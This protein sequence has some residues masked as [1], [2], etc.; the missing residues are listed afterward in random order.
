MRDKAQEG[1]DELGRQGAQA[2]AAGKRGGG[3]KEPN[4]RKGAG[5]ARR[6]NDGAGAFLPSAV[7]IERPRPQG[8]RSQRVDAEAVQGNDTPRA[9]GSQRDERSAVPES[10]PPGPGD[11]I[12]SGDDCRRGTGT[13]A[14]H[15]VDSAVAQREARQ[16][17]RKRGRMAP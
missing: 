5:R 8:H 2:A 7:P 10:R 16:K 17:D 9:L 3:M 12:R 15:P 6:H 1:T 4:A 14:D 13:M 11:G